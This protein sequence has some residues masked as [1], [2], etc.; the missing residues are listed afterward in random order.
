MICYRQW[1]TRKKVMAR[2]F[3]KLFFNLQTGGA[4]G[5]SRRRSAGLWVHGL[6]NNRIDLFELFLLT[7]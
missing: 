4:R 1:K 7:S 2:F 6:F 5:V 3:L